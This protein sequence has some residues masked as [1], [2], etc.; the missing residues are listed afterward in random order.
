[1]DYEVFIL[2]RIHEEYHRTGD[3]KGSVL[4]G[5]SSSARVITAAALIMISVFGAFALGDSPF[6][7]MFGLGLDTAVF[8]DATAV[9][10]VLVP[11]GMTLFGATP[12]QFHHWLHPLLP[13][14]SSPGESD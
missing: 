3:A 7:K 6:I 13:H 14:P 5:I 4:T 12:W 8:L 1:M 9:R 2:S 11:A 10:M